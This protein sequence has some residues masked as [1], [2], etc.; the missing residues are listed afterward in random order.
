M[1][2]S[3]QKKPLSLNDERTILADIVIPPLPKRKPAHSRQPTEVHPASTGE[4]VVHDFLVHN[5]K[6]ALAETPIQKQPLSLHDK[7]R[8]LVIPPAL[9]RYPATG[10]N[11]PRFTPLQALVS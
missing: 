2:T 7:L 11:A 10:N 8:A 1:E 9:A 3:L 4:C 6:S 5:T